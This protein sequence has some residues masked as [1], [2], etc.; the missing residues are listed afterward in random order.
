MKPLSSII[1]PMFQAC[2]KMKPI[3]SPFR[4]YFQDSLY[5]WKSQDYFSIFHSRKTYE[6]VEFFLSF[7][8]CKLNWNSAVGV[9]FYPFF[10]LVKTYWKSET[11]EFSF[12]PFSDSLNMKI[13]SSTWLFELAK[14]NERSSLQYKFTPFT[15]WNGIFTK[16]VYVD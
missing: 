13:L 12:K 5:S 7:I 6:N 9:H 8:A 2:I 14:G 4:F 10:K 3:L 11:M 15:D 1:F 16:K